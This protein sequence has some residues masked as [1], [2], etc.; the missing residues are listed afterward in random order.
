MWVGWGGDETGRDRE[1]AGESREDRI[2]SDI[3]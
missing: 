3:Q 2:K 1:R